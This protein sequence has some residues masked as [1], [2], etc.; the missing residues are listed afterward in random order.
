MAARRSS[1]SLPRASRCPGPRTLPA[2]AAHALRGSAP[3]PET[4]GAALARLACLSATAV[5]L[6]ACSGGDDAATPPPP[7]PPPAPASVSGVVADG[8]LQGATVCHDENDNGACD[9]GEPQATTDANGRYS[10]S[11]AADQA[12]RHAVLALVPA[13]AIDKDTG[14]AVG[15]AFTLKAPASGSSG[16]QSVFVSPL[17]TVVADTAEASGIPVAEA[18]AQ[19]KAALALSASPMADFTA[20]D[21][22]ADVALAARAVGRVVIETSRLAA[23]AGVAAAPASRLVRET[24]RSQLPVVANALAARAAATNAERIAAA[25]AAVAQEM[26]LSAATVAQVA[27][28]LAR[29]A[30]TADAAGPFVSV[31]RFS[32]TD[33]NNYSYQIFVGD[34]SQTDAS[35]AWLA[36]E[37]RANVV[38]G[39]S[40]AFSRNQLYWTGSAWNACDNGH[41]VVSTVAATASRPQT[42]LY[43]GASKS[44][45]RVVWEDISGQT[46]RAVITRMRAYPLRDAVGSTTNADGLPLNWGPDPALLPAEAS[47]PAGARY[48]SRQITTDIGGVDRIETAV[49]LTVRGSDGV[50]RQATTLEG[51]GTMGGNLADAAVT[52]SNQNSLFVADVPLATQADS[53]LQPFKRWRLAVDVAGLK[54]RFYRCDVLVSSGASQACETTGDATLAIETLGGIRLLR[55]AGGYPVALKEALFQQRFWAEH[56]GTVFRGTTDLQR[57]RSDQRLNKPAWDALRNALGIPEQTVPAAPAA[58]GAFSLLRNFS[59]TDAQN[60]SWRLY[61]GDQR[62]LDAAGEFAVNESRRQRT[63]GADVPFVRNRTYWTGS[64]WEACPDSGPLITVKPGTAPRSTFCKGYID[65]EAGLLT[66]SLGGRPMSDVIDQVR[67]YAS[68]DAGNT[69]WSGWGLAPG[70]VPALA[71]TRFPAGAELSI[72]AGR[73]LA[74]PEGI[75]T[76]DADRLRIAPSPTHH[77]RCVCHLAPGHH[78]GAGDRRLPGQPGRHGAERQHHTL[79]LALHRDARG[80]GPHQPGGDPRGLR[81]QRQQGAL[82]PQQPAGEQRLQHQLPDPAGHHLHDRAARG[83]AAAEVR[84][85]ARRFREPLLLHPALCRAGWRGLVRVQGRRAGGP[86]ELHAAPER[87]GLGRAAHHPGHPVMPAPGRRPAPGRHANAG[88]ARRRHPSPGGSR[89]RRRAGFV[90]QDPHPSWGDA[91]RAAGVQ[92]VPRTIARHRGA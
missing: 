82:H 85:H 49:G 6:A 65:E 84:G 16:T 26:N 34:S 88:P 20:S 91:G 24:A 55:V 87:H 25:A 14:T 89:C 35:G 48:S 4:A 8:P 7:A 80:P 17:T 53:T 21:G 10:F 2:T 54:G 83:H 47:F 63:A 15:A 76:S 28:V 32:Y 22:P 51:L 45:S 33:A 58:P 11:V 90:M 79:R 52:V 41:A 27:E 57:T 62:V 56:V 69:S 1:S 42:S 81:C 13:T 39:E 67:S 78:A 75:A 50:F 36:H 86:A 70:R 77:Q 12:G 37:P 68:T 74:V 61:T 18:V 66:I 40:I 38:N 44:E 92:R 3:K 30:G 59:W 43:C 29:P 5:L 19:V 46:L 9:A 23:D 60:Y 72:R 64:A 73:S 31:R 71:T